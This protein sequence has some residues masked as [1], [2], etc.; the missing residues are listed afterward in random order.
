MKTNER[1]LASKISEWMN[2]IIKRN[3]YPFT[4]S[5]NETGIKVGKSTKF[6]DLI[7]WK[8]R[9]ANEAYS[10]I[11]IKPPFGAN[12]NLVSFRQK[13]IELNVNFAFTWDFQ[14]L[15][16]YK[17][18]KNNIELVGTD[19][20]STLN[21]IDDWVRGDVQ[22]KIKAYIGKVF[23]ELLSLNES[24]KLQKFYPDKIYFINFIRKAVQSIVPKYEK[25]LRDS[26]RK[27]NNKFLIAEY[28]TKQGIAYPSDSEYYKLIASQTV[29]ALVTRIIFYLTI[30][31][32]FDDLP[33]I[34]K[35][36]EP[37]LS[38]LLE[39]AFSKAREKDWQ[40]VFEKD[41][42]EKLGIPD[43]VYD[44]IR[45]LLSEMQ[46]YHFGELSEDVIGELF[47]EIIDPNERHRLGQYFT[48]ED[49]VDLILG[50]TVQNKDGIYADPTC[51]SGTFLIRLYDRLKYLSASK[52]KH[53]ELLTR[54]WGIDIGKFPAELSTINLFRQEVANYENFPRVICSD[55]FNVHKGIIFRFPP[56]NA[57]I[58]IKWNL[59]Y[60]SLTDLLATSHLYD[61]N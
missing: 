57:S 24:G 14:N 7:I 59:N 27:S 8:N 36:D 55:I 29:Y 5:S 61:K 22:A 30:K 33:D 31:R 46:V 2:E 42:I 23:D 41:P 52:F 43:S 4:S 53:S 11:E 45:L 20:E 26:A 25:Y 39:L 6:G 3:N 51:G 19:T 28:A 37:D 13:A 17:V 15:H 12:E 47:E 58:L 38:K 9:E 48:N 1:E 35:T 18:D 54:I 32:Y 60:Q 34:Y 21:K 44:D 56:P 40:A 49:L 50:F 16:A 10:Y